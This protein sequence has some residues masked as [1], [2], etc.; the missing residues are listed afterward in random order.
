M[1]GILTGM[2]SVVMAKSGIDSLILSKVFTYRKNYVQEDSTLE[3]LLS[4]G[5][6]TEAPEE[7]CRSHCWN[8]LQQSTN[9]ADGIET[10]DP[11]PVRYCAL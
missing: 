4:E 9:H 7:Q 5:K 1:L 8:D 6:F 3:R 2:P 11:Y 10:D